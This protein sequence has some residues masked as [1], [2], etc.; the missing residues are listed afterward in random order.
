MNIDI[1]NARK[2]QFKI[3]EYLNWKCTREKK[4]KKKHPHEWIV[5]FKMQ[6]LKM[7]KQD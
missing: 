3:L 5:D 1:E 2:Q 4:K 7:M 6:K